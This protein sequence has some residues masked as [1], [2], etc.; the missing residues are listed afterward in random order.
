MLKKLDIGKTFMKTKMQSASKSQKQI[1]DA[2]ANEWYEFKTAP[3]ETATDLINNSKGKIL[4]FGSGAGR[5]LLNLK[6]SEQRELY[7]IDFSEKMILLAKQ[8]AKKL[9]LNIKTKVSEIEKTPF[10]DDFFDAVIC[11]SVIH[12]IKTSKKREQAIKEL[13]RI[14]K[15]GAKADIEVWNKNSPRF[16]NAPKE[17]LISWRDKG[18][19][20]YYFFEEEE[21][22]NLLEKTGFK[23][24]KQI[25]HKANIVFIAK[26]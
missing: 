24:L 14:L 1:W 18:K 19:R 10:K 11:V 15:P 12:C 9:G 7:L 22:K 21:L 2:I 26:K 13:Y 8:R 6:K 16:K 5:N 17:K 3:S 20:Y 25:P 4:D 23:I